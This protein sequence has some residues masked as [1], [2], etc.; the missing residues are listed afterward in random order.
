MD[1]DSPLLSFLASVQ[2]EIAITTIGA[3][4]SRFFFMVV[5]SESILLSNY[6]FS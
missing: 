3:N 6:R 1:L 5:F 2:E 4:K